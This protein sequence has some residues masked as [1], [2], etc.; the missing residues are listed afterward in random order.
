MERVKPMYSESTLPDA[1][2]TAY[3]GFAIKL[4][5]VEASSEDAVDK[6]RSVSGVSSKESKK[7]EYLNKLQIELRTD[8]GIQER[9]KK[10]QD[11]V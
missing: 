3:G 8:S 6:E 1:V 5:P 4:M 7:K 10:L 9:K 11:K 2:K